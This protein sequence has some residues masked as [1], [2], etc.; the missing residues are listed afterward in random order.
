MILRITFPNGT[1]EEF[2]I[3]LSAY[4]SVEEIAN[5]I[6]DS[7]VVEMKHLKDPEAWKKATLRWLIPAIYSAILEELSRREIIG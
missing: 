7:M 3:D 4:S 5:E 6:V 1:E 2:D